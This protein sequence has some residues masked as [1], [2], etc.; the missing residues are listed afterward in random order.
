MTVIEWSRLQGGSM[1]AQET[2]VYELPVEIE[3]TATRAVLE[4]PRRGARGLVL[5]AHGL[6]ASR[7][8]DYLR[9]IAGQLHAH[10]V[11]SVSMD[12]PLH[13]SRRESPHSASFKDWVADWQAFWR[14]GGSAQMAA[15]YKAILNSCP[16]D[17][18]A[19]PVGYWGTSLGTQC[20]MQWLAQDPR[21]RAAVLGQFRGDGLLMQR[22]APRVEIPVFFIRQLDDE[23]HPADVSHQLFDLLGSEQKLMRSSPG[24]H[25]EVPPGVLRESV[26]W[27]CER[28]SRETA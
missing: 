1:R 14:S 25:D 8:S 17:L 18:T 22:F 9:W 21:P 7:E 19:L 3:R 26:T 10:S 23:L 12:A 6:S 16:D 20:G 2:E 15:E 11:A 28:L 27:L 24:H 5:L 4:V 13:G